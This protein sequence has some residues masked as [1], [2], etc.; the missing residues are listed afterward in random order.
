MKLHQLAVATLS[1]A[2]ATALYAQT[3]GNATE[4]Q[5]D[6]PNQI[7]Q[8]WK[9][10]HHGGFFKQLDLTDA[11]KQQLKEYRTSNAADWKA[12]LAALLTAEKQLQNAIAT[13]PSDEAT[14]RS[15]VAQESNVRADLAIQRAHMVAQ[16]QSV[17]TPDQKQKLTE[18]EQKREAR[19]QRKIDHLTE[20]SS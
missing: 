1:L 3:T 19:M 8:N 9:G 12:K 11:Q 10:H 20:K 6:Q 18:L 14:I 13:N 7:E 17:L 5:P 16:L 15:L 2:T 4:Q